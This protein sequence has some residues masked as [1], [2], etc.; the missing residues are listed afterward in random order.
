MRRIMVI[1]TNTFR[2]AVRDRVLYNLV[3]F[4]VMMIGASLLVGRASIGIERL[5][6]VNLG[7]TSISLFGILISIFLGI[8]LVYKEMDK[9]TLYTVLAA[10]PVRRWEF[11]TGKWAGLVMTLVVNAAMM[12]VALFAGLL[13][14]SGKLTSAD[15]GV[16]A[17][18]YL[19]LLQYVLMTSLALLF[20]TFSTPLMSS[21]FAFALF[22]I[23]SYA[24]DLRRFANLASGFTRVVA[25]GMSYA[26]PNFAALN[27]I[28]PAAHAVPIS[29]KL[30]LLDSVY[31]FVYAGVCLS[32]SI[33]IFERRN[34]K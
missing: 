11:I 28:L 21:L 14:V 10:R 20:S 24:G 33:L 18:I 3:V 26:V 16:V 29:T 5:A 7:L 32:A 31:V 22:V 1:A 6:L 19:I 25:Y 27:M 2:E 34:L 8:G 12:S 13:Y 4:A 9:R 15:W 17:A 30:V 23:G